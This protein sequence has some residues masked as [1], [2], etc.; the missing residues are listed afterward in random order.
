MLSELSLI[1]PIFEETFTGNSLPQPWQSPE[2]FAATCGSR[3]CWALRLR[4]EGQDWWDGVLVPWGWQGLCA[5]Y[6]EAAQCEVDWDLGSAASIPTKPG[7][8]WP[9][10][11]FPL[12]ALNL[13]LAANSCL[14][15]ELQEGSNSHPWLG[16]VPHPQPNPLW[17]PHSLRD[18]QDTRLH[19]LKVPLFHTTALSCRAPLLIPE[20]TGS[21]LRG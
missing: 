18:R 21:S 11:N 12:G 8:G 13:C 7:K 17:E 19:F 10:S 9:K 15:V 20:Q 1:K 16:P 14:F 4:G 2:H 6:T 3:L 5:G